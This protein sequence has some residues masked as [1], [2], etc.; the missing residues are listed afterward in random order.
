VHPLTGVA[1]YFVLWWLVLFAVL[2]WGTRPVAEP[3]AQTGWRGAP[4]RP[5]LG[6]KVLATTLVSAVVWALVYLAVTS[7]TL[8]FRDGILKMH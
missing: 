1:V 6:R 7:D 4:E 3:D 2:P 8:G 5:Q